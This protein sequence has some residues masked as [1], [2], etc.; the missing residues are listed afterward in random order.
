MNDINN[1]ISNFI[2]SLN[3][4]LLIIIL[5][6]NGLIIISSLLITYLLIDSIISTF[7]GL[8][9]SVTIGV[10]ANYFIITRYKLIKNISIDLIQENIDDE[11]EEFQTIMK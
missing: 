6:L 7:F 11:V 10:M 4:K 1:N 2:Y 3:D 8:T 9:I 5:I